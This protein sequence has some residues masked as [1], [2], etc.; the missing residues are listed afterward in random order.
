MAI[1]YLRPTADATANILVGYHTGTNVAS[2]DMSAVYTGKSGVGP[3]GSSAVLSLNPLGGVQRYSQRIF[4]SWQTTVNSYSSLILKI[5]DKYAV[6]GSG[7]VPD[8]WYSTD[9]GSTWTNQANIS[10]S[11]ATW[12]VD[13]TGATLS[14]VQ[15]LLEV[16][17]GL[18]APSGSTLTVYDIWTEGTYTGPIS[19]PNY[20]I[21]D[22]G[23][24][25]SFGRWR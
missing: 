12:S 7:L 17:D 11:Q 13:I 15:V 16:Q 9:G 25:I 18:P 24:V 23:Q 21:D 19:S 3:T 6:S 2:S 8:M 4:S 5:S 1:E 14:N 20:A 22:Y 10:T